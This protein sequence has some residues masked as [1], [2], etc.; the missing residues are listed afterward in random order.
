MKTKNEKQN[1]PTVPPPCRPASPADL[2]E[3]ARLAENEGRLKDAATLFDA[4]ADG[5]TNEDA[6][7]RARSAAGAIL[8][9][10]AAGSW[11]K[12]AKP[13]PAPIPTK[14]EQIAATDFQ[15]GAVV[16][17]A[18]ITEKHVPR[19]DPKSWKCVRIYSAT[20]DTTALQIRIRLGKGATIATA[21]LND[22]ALD[23]LAQAIAAVQAYRAKVFGAK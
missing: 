6:K 18:P 2:E 23:E 10:I 17:N 12:V 13:A 20:P 9:M 19:Y 8:G 16:Q 4:A 1:A 3:A 5:Y 14:A 7:R 22:T 15:V 21:H 11:P